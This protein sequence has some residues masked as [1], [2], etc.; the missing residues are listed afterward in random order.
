MLKELGL[1]GTACCMSDQGILGEMGCAHADLSND[2]DA[3]FISKNDRLY[4]PPYAREHNTTA[5]NNY[6]PYFICSVS[7]HTEQSWNCYPG[8]PASAPSCFRR[9]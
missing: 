8:H 4:R 5:Y 1:R 9:K 3:V 2:V 6:V 7:Y